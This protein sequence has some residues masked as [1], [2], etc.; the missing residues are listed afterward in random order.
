MAQH[1][2]HDKQIQV[3]NIS[4]KK[5]FVQLLLKYS[6]SEGGNTSYR[7]FSEMNDALV[8]ANIL[9]CALNNEKLKHFLE[10]IVLVP[11]WMN[12]T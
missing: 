9:F 11:S 5:K 8:V 2:S 1:T 10:G 3:V 12:P 6:P 7:I 4:N